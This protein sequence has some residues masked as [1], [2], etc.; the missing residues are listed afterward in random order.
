M[1]TEYMSAPQAA[2]MGHFRKAGTDTLQRE[3]HTGRFK[4]RIYDVA[5]TKRRKKSQQI[6][7]NGRKS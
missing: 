5:D 2:E 1:E 3:P 6:K 4:T 7:E